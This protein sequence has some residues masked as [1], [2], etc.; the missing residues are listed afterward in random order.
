MVQ[1][2]IEAKVLEINKKELSHKIEETGAKK[3]FDSHIESY[4]YDFPD[5]RIEENGILRLRKTSKNVFITRK[6]EIAYDDAKEM[7]EIEFNV[8][9]MEEAKTFLNSIGLEKVAE[10]EKNRIKW[11]KDDVEYVIDKIPDVPHLL[12]I[13]APNRQKMK[14]SFE[15]LDISVEETV[16]WGA[17][18]TLKYYN[19]LD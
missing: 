8:S 15:E 1:N 9:S 16:N 11:V 19:L 6:K 7:E 13:E 12:E 17:E 5:G 14:D 10:S 3:V 4:F 18:K 2:E